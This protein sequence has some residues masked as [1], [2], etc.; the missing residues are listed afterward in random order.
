MGRTNEMTNV[1][2]DPFQLVLLPGLGADH[3]QFQPQQAAFADCLVPPWIPP[4]RGESL[5]GYAIRMAATV[6]PRSPM[7]LGGSS[8][9][10]MVA[11]EM[12]NHLKPKALVLIGSCRSGKATGLPFRARWLLGPLVSPSLLKL[13]KPIAPLAGALLRGSLRRYRRLCVAMFREA[14]PAFMSWAVRAI[15]TWEPSSVPDAP[16]FQIH[17]S[18]DRVI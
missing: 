8:F 17:G 2:E 18:N 10:G 6:E 16:V 13:A 3:R 14:D 12:A 5:A 1:K 9:G 11:Y 7:V 15:L 4:Q